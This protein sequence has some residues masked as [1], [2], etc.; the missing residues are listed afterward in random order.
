MQED[1]LHYG[2]AEKP[3]VTVCAL[4]A[5]QHI[6]IMAPALVYPI[7][8]LQAAGARL[9]DL[10]N[11]L[12]LS[13]V[14]L[15]IGAILQCL[16]YGPVGSR[17]LLPFIFTA[18]Y[19]PASLAAAQLG[20][21][22][23]VCGMTLFASA[24]EIALA[25]VVSRMR[26]FFPAEISGLCVTLI[27]L[28]LAILGIRLML[29][30]D[31]LRDVPQI[32]PR[33]TAIGIATLSLMIA[34]HIWASGALR[35]YA[36]IEAMFVG[37]VIS[38][39]SGLVDTSGIGFA[40]AAEPIHLPAFP[41][42]LPQFSL[43]LT[44]PFAV[45]ALACCLRA[46]GDIT[47]CQRLNDAKWIRPDF[48]SIR[49]GLL[50]DGVATGIGGIVGSMG[51]NTYSGSIGLSSATGVLSRWVGIYIGIGFIALAFTPIVPALLLS[52]PK[53]IMGAALVFTA[54]F[55]LVNGLRMITDRLLDSRR[56]VVIGV[57]LSLSISRDIL[58][59]FYVRLPDLV[60]PFVASDLTMGIIVALGLNAIFRIGIKQRVSTTLPV[61]HG[62]VELTQAFLEQQG[63][64]WSA[65][66]DIMARAIFGTCQTL[67]VILEQGVESD[68]IVIEAAFDEYK[69]EIHVKYRGEPLQLSDRR[70]TD[71]EIREQADGMK[72]LAGYLIRRNA[73]RVDV[74]FGQDRSTVSLYFDH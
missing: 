67:E 16:G 11:G 40:A 38:L 73:D 18:A 25:G 42:R 29:G 32:S 45:G 49:G 17:F 57:A 63:A 10:V 71:A 1:S 19:L 43:A 2:L 9:S 23:L 64:R 27:G 28:V 72:K 30:V 74:I 41:L 8:V 24:I 35:T 53:P 5:I 26:P 69:L 68:S 65:R 48:A 47:V 31:P 7:L 36:V 44:I 55:V 4:Q 33:A 13:F 12:S 6:A 22:A 56:T 39:L 52:I 3:P 59:D 21:M 66:R 58:P 61:E 20:G 46:M 50:A 54:C 60:Q 51:G 34:L 62:A 14:A 37:Y 70:P 15:G